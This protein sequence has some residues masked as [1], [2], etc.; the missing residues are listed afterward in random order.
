M[1]KSAALGYKL[2][3]GY[4]NFDI[5]RERR[6]RA[7]EMMATQTEFSLALAVCAWCRPGELGVGLGNVSHGICPRHFEL[8]RRRLQRM[9]GT[10]PKRS[11]RR[12]K[13]QREPEAEFAFSGF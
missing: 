5:V 12:S 13:I 10:P 9:A 4:G 11:S 6:G 7:G 2:K 3:S 8:M 1:S